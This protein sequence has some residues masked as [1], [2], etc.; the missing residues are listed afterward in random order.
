M[1]LDGGFQLTGRSLTGHRE[2]YSPPVIF[3]A[4]PCRLK[5]GRDLRMGAGQKI[6]KSTP[7]NVKPTRLTA[8]VVR[9]VTGTR[10][11][12]APSSRFLI[13]SALATARDRHTEQK[14]DRQ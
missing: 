12:N 14:C 8:L 11:I 9:R 2:H 1:D 5:A 4:D 6:A 3:S 7:C 13:S 10:R